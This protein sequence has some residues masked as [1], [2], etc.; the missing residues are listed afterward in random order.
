MVYLDVISRCNLVVCSRF[1]P[2]QD[3]IPCLSCFGLVK[4][5]RDST[6]YNTNL[7]YNP[8]EFLN[9]EKVTPENVI[10]SFG[11]MLLVLLIGKQI[12]IGQA[13]DMMRN[14]DIH[15]FLDSHLKG[16][17]PFKEATALVQLASQCLQYHPKDR[18]TLTG[19]IATLEEIQSKAGVSN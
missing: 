4:N 15:T 7:A 6:S 16:K 9:D 2:L 11:T 1:V 19:V 14:Y 13:L 10:F 5:S 18:P 8:P 3:D 17:Y 12:P